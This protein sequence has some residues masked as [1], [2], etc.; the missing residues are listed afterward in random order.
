MTTL[1][2]ALEQHLQASGKSVKTLALETGIGYAT[3]LTILKRGGVPRKKEHRLALQVAMGLDNARW[4]DLVASQTSRLQLRQPSTQ[5]TA[6]PESELTLQQ[7]IAQAMYSQ[8]FTEQSLAEASGVPYPTVLGVTRRGSVPRDTTVTRLADFLKLD[9][10]AICDAIEVSLERRNQHG[11][12]EHEPE[13]IGLSQLVADF[14]QTREQSLGSFARDLG[15]SYFTLSR[16]LDTGIVPKDKRVLNI[17]RTAINCTP[18]YFQSCIQ[19]SQQ[20]PMPAEMPEFDDILPADANP[21]QHALAD[22]MRQHRLNLK[23]LARRA[24]LS[25]VT[26]SRIVKQGQIP[27]RSTTHHKLQTLLGMNVATYEKLL[28]SSAPSAALTARVRDETGSHRRDSLPLPQAKLLEPTDA[29]VQKTN[30]EDLDDYMPHETT[31]I[32]AN[33]D[34]S[35]DTDTLLKLIKRMD[36]RQ[37]KALHKLIRTML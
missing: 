9:G 4:N 29:P 11:E 8:G 31:L 35:N 17:L 25:Q 5:T 27:R 12:G 1:K 19:L 10:S 3:L 36:N 22:Y 20:K 13:P 32:Q 24:D 21:L 18:E 28:G 6:A 33:P 26:V 2:E 37:R 15:L 23:S 7:L 16:L 30:E 34:E 14:L